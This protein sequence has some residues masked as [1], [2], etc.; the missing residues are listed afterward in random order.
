MTDQDRNELIALL[1]SEVH[2]NP[3]LT[4]MSDEELRR[5]IARAL[6]EKGSRGGGSTRT[7]CASSGG[8]GLPPGTA[9]PRRKR[10]PPPSTTAKRP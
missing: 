8:Y 4:V 6:E 2:Q 5:V 3:D 10:P 7:P 9:W 1:K